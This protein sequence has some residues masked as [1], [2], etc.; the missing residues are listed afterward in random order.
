QPFNLRVA[1][2]N[3]QTIGAPGKIYDIAYIQF[4]QGDLIRGIGLGT[5]SDTPRD[6]RRV[7]AQPMHDPASQSVNFAPSA[8]PAG[9]MAIASDGS[10]AAFVPARRA[11]TWQLANPAG[12][13]AV[14]ERMW[15]TFQ[16]GEVRVCASC[17]GANQLD[18]AGHTP[19]VNQAQ[20]FEELLRQWKLQQSGTGLKVYLPMARR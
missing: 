10:M 12:T 17:H 6:G 18:Q 20:A 9:S 16:P 15:V 3:T 1:G 5:S 7:L 8:G 19:P 14:R 2:N 4:F 13:P 11:M